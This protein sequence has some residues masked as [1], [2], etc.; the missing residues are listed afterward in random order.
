MD[1]F[2][3]ESPES[4]HALMAVVKTLEGIKK[5]PDAII[6]E[7]LNKEKIKEDEKLHEQNYNL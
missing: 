6:A 7:E 4:S 5:L 3:P 2:N 1:Q